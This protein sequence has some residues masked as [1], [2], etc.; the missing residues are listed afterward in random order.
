MCC[1][2]PPSWHCPTN[3]L[4]LPS[5]HSWHV[6]VSSESIIPHVCRTVL[7]HVHGFTSVPLHDHLL[8][9]YQALRSLFSCPQG[10]V[11]CCSRWHR[12]SEWGFRRVWGSLLSPVLEQICPHRVDHQ[13]VS[14]SP[15]QRKVFL[16][17][18]ATPFLSSN[19]SLVTPYLT[20][21]IY[22]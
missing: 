2:S 9:S 12:G 16:Q 22:E 11:Q 17:F 5:S 7:S 18:S 19:L 4:E 6:V 20:Q 14:M 8:F 3:N 10:G 21:I 15:E 13:C 1:W